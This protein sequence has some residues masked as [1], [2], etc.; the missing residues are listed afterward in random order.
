MPPVSLASERSLDLYTMA[1]HH[2]GIS[3]F[4]G[5]LTE[6]PAWYL[7]DEAKIRAAK[8]WATRKQR[9][10]AQDRKWAESERAKML[11]ES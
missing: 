6:W 10:T 5:P 2:P 9:K 7:E 1:Q 3:L 8:N 4:P 11:E